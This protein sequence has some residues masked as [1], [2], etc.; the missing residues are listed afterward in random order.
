MILLAMA[1]L[2]WTRQAYPKGAPLCQSPWHGR[3]PSGN[4]SVQGLSERGSRVTL[5]VATEDP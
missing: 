4:L 3:Q 1:I 2:G 5:S